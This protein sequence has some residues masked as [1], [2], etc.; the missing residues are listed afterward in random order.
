MSFISQADVSSACNAVPCKGMLTTYGRLTRNSISLK[1]PFSS[2]HKW[3]FPLPPR[4]RWPEDQESRSNSCPDRCVTNVQRYPLRMRHRARSRMCGTGPW[5]IITRERRKSKQVGKQSTLGSITEKKGK[6]S[7]KS[8]TSWVGKSFFTGS[9]FSRI[10]RGW[11]LFSLRKDKRV[12]Q[13]TF[14]IWQ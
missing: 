4:R 14:R 7:V 3:V 9:M 13:K 11:T 6:D 5:K 10:I 12:M 2:K 1:V 8:E